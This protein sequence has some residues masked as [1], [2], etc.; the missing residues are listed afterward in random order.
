MNTLIEKSLTSTKGRSEVLLRN[1]VQAFAFI[2][3]MQKKDTKFDSIFLILI[4]EIEKLIPD[5]NFKEVPESVYCEDSS[6]PEIKKAV[7][8]V[9]H[10]I[11]LLCVITGN[12]DSVR[13][14]KKIDKDQMSKLLSFETSEKVATF[15]GKLAVIIKEINNISEDSM[16]NKNPLPLDKMKEPI[17]KMLQIMYNYFVTP[18]AYQLLC[19]IPKLDDY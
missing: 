13:I 15:G 10:N 6:E 19:E 4:A 12:E 7:I 1:F 17:R 14:C 18:R 11:F 16:V 8:K 9:M 3:K 5:L 2:Q